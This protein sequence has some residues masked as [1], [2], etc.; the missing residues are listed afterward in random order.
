MLLMYLDA[1]MS[2]GV[3]LES[4]QLIII[5]RRKIKSTVKMNSLLEQLV[6]DSD[7]EQRRVQEELEQYKRKKSWIHE[8]RESK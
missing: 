1:T 5:F 8:R 3:L 6:Q 7:T 4:P 2:Q